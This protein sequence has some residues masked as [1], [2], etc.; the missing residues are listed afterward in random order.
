MQADVS[1]IDFSYGLTPGF[2]VIQGV[3]GWN[4]V[5]INNSNN[6]AIEEVDYEPLLGDPITKLGFVGGLDPGEIIATC[7]NATYDDVWGGDAITQFKVHCMYDTDIIPSTGD[8]GG[9]YFYV[10][11]FFG[12]TTGSD[13]NPGY[14]NPECHRFACLQLNLRLTTRT[15]TGE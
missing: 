8:S 5:T 6:V 7:Q 14:A 10:A 1:M 2:P 12:I 9:I 4:S 3:T 13:F 11:T 15:I